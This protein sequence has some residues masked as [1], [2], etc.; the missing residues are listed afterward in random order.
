MQFYEHTNRVG[1]LATTILQEL[2]DGKR[3][4][5][6]PCTTWLKNIAD[7]MGLTTSDLHTYSLDRLNWKETI[8]AVPH[9]V[10]T[11]ATV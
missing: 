4:R 6:R 5:G 7:W 2:V 10:P 1:N 9:D 3:G 8:S 11:T